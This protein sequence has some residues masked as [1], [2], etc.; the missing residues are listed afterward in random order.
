MTFNTTLSYLIVTI[1]TLAFCAAVLYLTPD[2]GTHTTVLVM[3][4]LAV[5]H[6]FGYSSQ[7]TNAP[8]PVPVPPVVA[9]QAPEVP[10]PTT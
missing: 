4:G 7:L 5:G 2:Q 8:G 1:A 10:K 6:W 9:P 3:A